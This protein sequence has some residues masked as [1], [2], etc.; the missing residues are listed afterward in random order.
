MSEEWFSLHQRLHVEFMNGRYHLAQVG[1]VGGVV[2]GNDH[3]EAAEIRWNIYSLNESA[4]NFL[5]LKLP[6]HTF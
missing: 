1:G 5:K 3:R 4:K 2:E 6:G